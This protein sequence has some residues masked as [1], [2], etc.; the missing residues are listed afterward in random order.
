[1]RP[2]RVVQHEA[3]ASHYIFNQPLKGGDTETYLSQSQK[4][5][6]KMTTQKEKIYFCSAFLFFH[7][8]Y[9]PAPQYLINI[10]EHNGLPRSYR[11]L[12]L[13]KM[14]INEAIPKKRVASASFDL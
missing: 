11:L 14:H 7:L 6:I 1:V 5:N 4:A 13:S 12:G 9:N 3:K 10:I 8:I 2:F